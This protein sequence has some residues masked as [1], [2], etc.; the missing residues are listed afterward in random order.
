MVT[1]PS[2]ELRLR[3][4][5]PLHNEVAVRSRPHRIGGRVDDHCLHANARMNVPAQTEHALR[6]AVAYCQTK[7]SSDLAAFFFVQAK[8]D[9]EIFLESCDQ[10]QRASDILGRALLWIGEV[11]EQ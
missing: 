5:R 2:G 7:G 6:R 4:K 1:G 10:I 9:I 3:R 8:H 11:K